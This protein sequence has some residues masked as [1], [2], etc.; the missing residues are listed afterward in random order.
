MTVIRRLFA[1]SL[2]PALLG[3]FLVLMAGT[4]I[5]MP[6]MWVF[7]YE[8]PDIYDVP[9]WLVRFFYWVAGAEF[10]PTYW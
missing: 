7:G 9:V 3:A 8:I 6:L 10:D 1:L 5:W 4:F 2:M